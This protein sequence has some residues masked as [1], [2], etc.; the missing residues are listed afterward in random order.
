MP[1]LEKILQSNKEKHFSSFTIPDN[2]RNMFSWIEFIV[3]KN[4]PFSFVDDELVRKTVRLEKICSN[5]LLKYMAALSNQ[6][7]NKLKESLPRKFGIGF[8]GWTE[9]TDHYIALFACYQIDGVKKCPLLAFQPIPDYSE[10]LESNYTLDALAHE[11]FI[12]HTLGTIIHILKL[13]YYER[14]SDSLLFLVGDNCSTNRAL[15]TRLSVPLVGC[16]SHRLNLANF[17]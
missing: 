12:V 13:E 7:E 14:S 5:T 9:G 3:T 6:V 15:A 10:S 11:T 1:S 16:A 17:F 2:D 8:D 4:I